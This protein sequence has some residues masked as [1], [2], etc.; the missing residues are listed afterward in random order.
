MYTLKLIKG[1]VTSVSRWDSISFELFDKTK[2][3][4]LCGHI[5]VEIGRGFD[6]EVHDSFYVI[7]GNGNTV[8]SKK[9]SVWG[10]S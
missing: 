3:K 10:A 7:D 5:N 9:A 4:V 8:L 1:S 2:D 6:V